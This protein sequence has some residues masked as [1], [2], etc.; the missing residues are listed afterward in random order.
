MVLNNPDLNNY[1]ANIWNNPGV[2][3]PIKHNKMAEN[4]ILLNKKELQELIV[5][6]VKNAMEEFITTPIMGDTPK[7]ETWTLEDP[8]LLCCRQVCRIMHF[9]S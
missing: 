1:Y 6:A 5:T 9:P 8:I 3:K 4:Y 2:S 7:E